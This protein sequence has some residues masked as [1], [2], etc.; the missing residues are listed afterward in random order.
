MHVKRVYA[1]LLALAAVIPVLIHRSAGAP[2]TEAL[3]QEIS[4]PTSFE[5]RELRQ[6][7]L[8]SVEQR[9]AAQFPGHIGRF[10]DGRRNMILRV[11]AQPTRLLHPAADCFRGLGYRVDT[12]RVT[13][14]ASG[15]AWSCFV[16]SKGGVARR[17][18]ERIYDTG[19]GMW[20]DVS[21]W[22][23]AAMLGHTRGPWFA[24]TVAE[25]S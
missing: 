11:V 19:G 17:V 2:R 13:V 3:A 21:A 5:G 8:S 15:V 4:W 16:A 25:G 14:D 22:Y 18:C 20:T 1:A 6:L 10:T 24:L 7:P 12:A 23:W 9:F